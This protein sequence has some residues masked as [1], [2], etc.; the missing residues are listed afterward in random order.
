MFLVVTQER[1]A[2][3]GRNFV[4]PEAETLKNY[5]VVVSTMTTAGR[6]L[7]CA[8]VPFILKSVIS[9][10]VVVAMLVGHPEHLFYV[11][12]TCYLFYEFQ[13]GKHGYSNGSFHPRVYG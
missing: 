6:Y 10:I 2:T 7:D 13:N 12:I 11:D 5:R 8:I 4:V 9:I 1:C 3:E